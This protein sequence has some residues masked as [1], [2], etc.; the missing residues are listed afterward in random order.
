MSRRIAGYALASLLAALLCAQAGVSQE[1]PKPAAAKAAKAANKAKTKARGR[2]PNNWGKLGITTTQREKI[3]DIQARYN[4][5]IDALEA[6]LAEL[7]MKRDQEAE[8]VLT[9]EQRKQLQQLTG[10]DPAAKPAPE[11]SGSGK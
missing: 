11:A 1:T 10:K 8:A 5:Q 2:L 7:K 3:Y 4:E 6:Q 9:P